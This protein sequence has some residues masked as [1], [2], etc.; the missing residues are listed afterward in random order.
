MSYKEY[1]EK[2]KDNLNTL[3]NY[4]EK[5]VKKETIKTQIDVKK[6]IILRE[7]IENLEYR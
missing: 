4:K 7:K 5:I 6:H 1:S 3:E 2:N